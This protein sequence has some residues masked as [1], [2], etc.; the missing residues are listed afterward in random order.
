MPVGDG[1]WLVSCPDYLKVSPAMSEAWT[2]RSHW[3]NGAIG[4]MYPHGT[5][6][7]VLQAVRDLDG[8]LNQGQYEAMKDKTQS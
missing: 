2:A 8:G 5:P 1:R 6:C 3:L 7:I 4:Q